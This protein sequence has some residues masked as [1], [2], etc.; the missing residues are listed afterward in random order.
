MERADGDGD[1][2]CVATRPVGRFR[3]VEGR[4]EVVLEKPEGAGRTGAP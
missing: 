3:I 4:G 2:T 1:R